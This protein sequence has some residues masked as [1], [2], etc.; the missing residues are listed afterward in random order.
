MGNKY[1]KNLCNFYD[2]ISSDESKTKYFYFT[3]NLCENIYKYL[4][5][6][7]KRGICS[8]F[9]FRISLL[10]V[11]DQFENKSINDSNDKKISDILSFYVKR[12]NNLKILS[13]NEINELINI[14][15]DAKLININ[16]DNIEL[17]DWEINIMKYEA[18]EDSDN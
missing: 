1:P 12:N 4:N 11:I 7:L 17:N 18:D 15:N 10:A 3:N 6:F 13:I 5:T 14:D 8:N 16:K 9:L 2:I